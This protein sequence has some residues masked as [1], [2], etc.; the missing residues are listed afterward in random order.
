MIS[1]GSLASATDK[2]KPNAKRD[3][4]SVDGNRSDTLVNHKYGAFR[5]PH[6]AAR[7]RVYTSVEPFSFFAAGRRALMEFSRRPFCH[8]ALAARVQSTAA[9]R[10]RA[11][12]AFLV[13]YL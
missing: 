10:I 2:I 13:K 1:D 4:Y 9:T 5:K 6:D 8:A 7:I 3:Y 11:V 12:Y